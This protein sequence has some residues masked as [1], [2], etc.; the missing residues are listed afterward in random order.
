MNL[1][2]LI[3]Q[4]MVHYIGTGCINYYFIDNDNI[5]YA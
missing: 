1:I 5:D 3:A 4:N 2:E